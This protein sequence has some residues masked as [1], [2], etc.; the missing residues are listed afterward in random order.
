MRMKR[1]DL[2]PLA[3]KKVLADGDRLHGP[4]NGA[5]KWEKPEGQWQRK[6]KYCSLDVDDIALKPK[7][8]FRPTPIKEKLQSR[9]Y[10]SLGQNYT[11]A[12]LPSHNRDASETS[13]NNN[14]S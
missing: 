7:D 13:S 11:E 4:L 2:L 5:L 10:S 3:G 6:A 9:N 14:Y 8:Q 1:Q 12:T